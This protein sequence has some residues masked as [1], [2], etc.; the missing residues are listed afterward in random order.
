[1]PNLLNSFGRTT[2]C[3]DNSGYVILNL[4]GAQ[5]FDADTVFFPGKYSVVVQAGAS[6]ST[7]N[8]PS[9]PESFSGKIETTINIPVLFII[10]AYCGS[11]ALSG[12]L[13]G[14]NPYSGQYKVNGNVNYGSNIPSVNHIFG[15][16]GS[17]CRARSGTTDYYPSSGNCLGD[18]FASQ[19]YNDNCATGAGSC[20][21]FLPMGGTFGID[22][23]FAAHCTA[24]GTGSNVFYN[25]I[26]AG[27]MGGSGSALGG[28]GSASSN[29]YTLPSSSYNGG[30]TP[31]G[32]GGEGVSGGI[33]PVKVKPGKN[34]T[35][36]G[37][38][39]GG[40]VIAKGCTTPGAAAYFDGTQWIES[41]LVAGAREEG[42]I[43]IT[44]MGPLD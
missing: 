21:H 27:N 23:L 34:G 44:Y 36:I 41:T 40:G 19:V 17:C 16:A 2:T 13:A 7:S 8:N 10:R 42:K 5:K 18:G 28:A 15:N 14:T 20:L 30:S 22:Y 38:G 9:T 32:T 35:G 11:K 4:S 31:Y 26:F 39:F 6:K 29:D 37:H 12:S 25:G 33:E 1:M 3:V 43:I 24:A